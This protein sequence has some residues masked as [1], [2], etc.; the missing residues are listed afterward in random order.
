MAVEK[1]NRANISKTANSIIEMLDNED[2]EYKVVQNEIWNE[3]NISG[4]SGRFYT[5]RCNKRNNIVRIHYWMPLENCIV[6]SKRNR[7]L[8][9]CNITNR[10]MFLKARLFPDG[11]DII[12]EIPEGAG[13]SVA[14]IVIDVLYSFEKSI[15]QKLF[16]LAISTDEDLYNY[17]EI[18]ESKVHEDIKRMLEKKARPSN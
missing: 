8:Q 9:A 7:L 14:E 5:I 18:R 1:D 12:Y 11:I 4:Q 6:E 15:D 17:Y 13:V 2:C 16:D 10:E 3:I